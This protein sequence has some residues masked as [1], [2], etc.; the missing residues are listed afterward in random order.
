MNNVDED[1]N[2][3]GTFAVL[4]LRIP[5]LVVQIICI[6]FQHGSMYIAEFMHTVDR[7]LGDRIVRAARKENRR[8]R[9]LTLK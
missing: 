9:L 5:L 1:L 8:R 3:L 2:A 6:G 4:L 7:Q